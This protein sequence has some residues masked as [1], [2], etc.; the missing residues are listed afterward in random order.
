MYVPLPEYDHDVEPLSE[1]LPP[2]EPLT[3]CQLL[4]DPT[5][6]S[7]STKRLSTCTLPRSLIVPLPDTAPEAENVPVPE[8]EP[9]FT[10]VH[11]VVRLPGVLQFPLASWLFVQ[12][13]LNAPPTLPDAHAVPDTFDVTTVEP[14]PGT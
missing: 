10:T 12:L 7:L 3:G 4:P 6:D 9:S 11:V 8:Y 13:P 1:P 5:I 14:E 2:P